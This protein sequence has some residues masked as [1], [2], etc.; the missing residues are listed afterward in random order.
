MIALAGT[1]GAWAA[2]SAGA[3]GGS[4]AVTTI[5]V[6]V[7]Q[8]GQGWTSP[9]AGQQ[10]FVLHDTDTRA[11]DVMLTAAGTGAV[12]AEVEPIGAGTTANLDI[13]LGSGSYAFQCA[14]EDTDTVVGPTVT[15]PGSAKGTAV[16]VAA[17]TQAD[18]LGPAGA[19]QSYVD[20]ALP[21]LT[22]LTGTLAADVASGDLAAARTDW[23]PAHLAYERLGA[24]YGAFGDLDTAINGTAAGRPGGVGDTG[25]AGFHRLEYGLWHGQTASTLKPVATALQQ[26]VA[27][28]QAQFDR[29][30]IDPRE[31]A[32]RAHEI[33]ENAVQFELTGRTDYGSGSNLATVRANLEG[34]QEVLSLVAPLLTP[35]Y[36]RTSTVTAELTHAEKDLDAT[37][38]PPLATL[39]TAS[40]ERIDADLSQLTED[41]APVAT[42]LEP[43]RPVTG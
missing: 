1:G 32:I 34:T 2:T 4:P 16:A 35:R 5:T 22:S 6:S 25:F 43:R 31:V 40:R 21:S 9:K 8:C 33:T 29:T 13:D 14:M 36:S 23:L 20:G 12:Y 3:S 39:P 28:L 10:H 37:G 18:M 26:S 19:Y 17:V 7:S 41:L 30:Q 15:L 24:A 38:Y 42:I 27:A 11:G